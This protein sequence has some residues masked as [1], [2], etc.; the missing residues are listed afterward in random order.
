MDLAEIFSHIKEL[1]L[2]APAMSTKEELGKF[3]DEL[4][5]EYHQTFPEL[6]DTL[7]RNKELEKSIQEGL[8]KAWG[9]NKKPD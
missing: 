2:P 3:A 8:K 6:L 9:L 1:G 5:R 4:K 7:K